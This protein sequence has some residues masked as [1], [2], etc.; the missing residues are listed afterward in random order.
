MD[1]AV[2]RRS[3]SDEGP[4]T[5]AAREAAALLKAL[6]HEG[7]LEILCLLLENPCTVGEMEEALGLPQAAVSQQLMRLRGDGLVRAE[8]EGRHIRYS[9]E[10]PE[11]RGIIQEL[12]RAFCPPE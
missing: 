11:V 1:G 12:Q 2:K 9:L 7:R 4:L 10:R 6:A 3:F 5:P 8:R